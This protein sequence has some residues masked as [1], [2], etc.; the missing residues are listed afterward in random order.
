MERQ[1]NLD[2]TPEVQQ[3]LGAQLMEMIRLKKMVDARDQMLADIE[4][5]AGSAKAKP[6]S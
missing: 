6:K 3:T 5:Q 2:I 1:D 4:K